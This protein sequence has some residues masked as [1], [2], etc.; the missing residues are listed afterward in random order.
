[1]PYLRN[2]WSNWCEIKRKWVNWMLRWLGYLWPWPLTL[3]FIVK[4]YLGN[5]RPECHGT[6]GTGVDRMPWCETLKKR[7]NCMLHWLGYLWPWIFKV[8]LYLGNGRPDCHGMKGTGVNRMPWCETQRKLVNWMLGWLGYLW[9]WPLVL[10]FQGQLY[11]GNGRPNCHGTKG[12]GVDRMPWCETLRKWV[13]RA[14]CWLGY[15]WLY[16]RPWIF[17]VKLYLGNGRPDCHGMKGTGVN[18]I[19]GLM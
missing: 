15:L 14:L 1:M 2:G 8:K 3:N 5:G 10:N 16:P 4:L 18:S 6:K 11:L 13:K 7:V 19:H 9:P 12:T 17:K